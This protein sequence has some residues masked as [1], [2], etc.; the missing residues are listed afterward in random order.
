MHNYEASIILAI[1]INDFNV[2][3]CLLLHTVNYYKF[4]IIKFIAIYKIV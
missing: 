4:K 3:K 2:S 1:K